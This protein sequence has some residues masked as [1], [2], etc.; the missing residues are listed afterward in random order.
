MESVLH[1][2]I[3]PNFIG[4]GVGQWKHTIKLPQTRVV[5]SFLPS[6]YKSHRCDRCFRV[7]GELAAGETL[8]LNQEA[9][10]VPPVPPSF[11]NGCGVIDIQYF[12]KVQFHLQFTA[13]LLDGHFPFVRE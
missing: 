1:I 12:L 11:L 4:I 8:T 5:D 7:A 3:E 10:K 13:T 9:L 6:F 2:I